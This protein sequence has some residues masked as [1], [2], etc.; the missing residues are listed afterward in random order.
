MANNLPMLGR[1][2]VA[3]VLFKHAVLLVGLFVLIFVLISVIPLFLTPRYLAEAEI[4]LQSG[5]EYQIVPNARETLPVAPYTT[6]Q[7]IIN[8]EIEILRSRDLIES[9][10]KT[11]GLGHLYPDIV[12][13]GDSETAQ[14]NT[15]VDRFLR[16]FASDAVTLSNVIQIKYWHPN[17]DI[18]IDTLRQLINVYQQ[19]HVDVFGD[20]QSQFLGTQTSN[21]EKQLEQ[22]TQQITDLKTSQQLSDI[23]YEREQLIQDRSDVEAKLRD[24]KSQAIS[25]HRQI[26]YY[27]STL[28]S[29]P[30]MILANQNSADAVETAKSKLLDLRNQLL[31]LQQRFSDN[32]AEAAGPIKDLKNQIS[33]IQQFIN[34]PAINQQRQLGRNPAYDAARL[35][36]QN[37]EEAA[38]SLDQTIVLQEAEYDK[39]I[40]RLETLDEGQAKLELLTREHDMLQE[41]VHTY[42]TRYEEARIDVDLDQQRMISV[43]T[44]EAPGA[45]EAP[46]TPRHWIF[47]IAGVVVGLVVTGFVVLYLFAFKETIITVESLERILGVRVLG[48]IPDISGGVPPRESTAT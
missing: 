5:R 48:S 39:I 43:S 21:Y 46:D 18:A 26:D 10:I 24:L 8:S 28:K 33:Q 45:K 1:R 4:L 11:V 9:V 34:N 16:T 29:M 2:E 19:K 20:K 37:A 25:A 17:R 14:M 30:E 23:V 6:K 7:E 12:R 22:V 38:P 3:S 31:Q 15:A 13:G 40:Q 36:L 35:K 27:T 32:N 47:V 42:R 41:L 44:I